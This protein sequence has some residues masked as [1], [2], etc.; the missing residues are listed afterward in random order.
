MMN[1]VFKT[2]NCV[3]KTR[4]FV[5]QTMDFAGFKQAGIGPVTMEL[6]RKYAAVVMGTYNTAQNLCYYALA[7]NLIGIFLDYG[8]CPSDDLADPPVR[9]LEES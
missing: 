1:F 9:F 4:N 2:R 5:L 6:S 7:N 8:M 3:S